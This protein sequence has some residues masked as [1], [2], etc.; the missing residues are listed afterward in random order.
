MQILESMGFH[1]RL[2]AL[3]GVNFGLGFQFLYAE[4]CK[5]SQ[6]WK[7]CICKLV[8]PAHETDLFTSGIETH[9]YSQTRFL[10]AGSD[11]VQL[12]I[13]HLQWRH[14]AIY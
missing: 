11:A 1:I 3:Q 8:W 4:P 2:D 5:P 7:F 9:I 10:K 6:T 12:M 13:L 14:K